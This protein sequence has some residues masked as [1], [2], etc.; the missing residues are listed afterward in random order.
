M[1][2]RKTVWFLLAVALTLFLV[3]V[4]AA[5]QDNTTAYEDPQGRFSAAIPAGWAAESTT[6]Y[7]LF[8]KEGVSVYLLAL[9]AASPE[10]AIEAA[11]PLIAPDFAGTEPFQTGTIPAPN[12]IW[13]QHV[14]GSFVGKIGS[15]VVQVK[16]G[17]GC[18]LYGEAGNLLALQ[19]ANNDVNTI[20][21]SIVIGEALDLTGVTP[22]VLGAAELADIEAYVERVMARDGIPGAAV[23]I[24]QNG[25]VV[26]AKGFGVRELDGDQPVDADTLFLIG[27]ITKSFTAMLMATLVEDGTLTWDTPVLDILPTFQLS[28]P[29]VTPQ[30][31]IRDLLTMSTGVQRS[32]LILQLK[33]GTPQETIESL[34]HIPM[35]AQPGEQYNYS[36]Q[37]VATGGYVAALA[38]GAAYDDDLIAAYGALVQARIFDPIG[39]T[40]S[41]LD[42]EAAISD[43]NHASPTLYSPFTQAFH[44][45]DFGEERFVIQD[46]PAGAIWSTITDM[47]QYAATQ[48]AGG[49][50]PNGTRVVAEA[51][52]AETR[53][54]GLP[55]GSGTNYAMGWEI[56]DY[57]GL[58]IV[59]HNGG[60][61]GFTSDLALLPEA[62]L[63]VVVLS[64]RIACVFSV[65]AVRD[66]IFETAFG[67]EHTAD[68]VYKASEERLRGLFEGLTAQL[69]TAPD[70][71]ALQQY[72]GD[73]TYLDYTLTIRSG[74]DKLLAVLPGGDSALYPMV[75]QPGAFVGDDALMSLL[76]IFEGSGD[77]VTVTLSSLLDDQNLTLNKAP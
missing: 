75:G 6:D 65:D 2:T 33:Y 42:F 63:A 1:V 14:Y 15:I 3:A 54:P 44:V 16:D 21:L 29:D 70:P 51:S 43:G 47:A 77:N 41:T 27:S 34:A 67:L 25:Q 31:R 32:D 56:G 62:N 60:A 9:E 73:Y 13:T 18:V 22:T 64:N 38:A 55:T 12:G 7:A 74:D 53:I 40:R 57:N 39:M 28:D 10:A 61:G 52:L 72:V 58:Q 17:V 26:M 24:I 4:P 71:A 30:I 37:M 23:A 76:A 68:T 59:K 46:S 50:A 36:N 5:A 20:L 49:V 69:D 19:A 8:T 48:L 45:G 66:Y 11:L 35:N